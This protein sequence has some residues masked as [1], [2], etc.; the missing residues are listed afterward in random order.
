MS[1]RETLR[2]RT[3]LPTRDRIIVGALFG[4]VLVPLLGFLLFAMASSSGHSDPPASRWDWSNATEHE[5]LVYIDGQVGALLVPGDSGRHQVVGQGLEPTPFVLAARVLS[6]REGP[7]IGYVHGTPQFKVFGV[8]GPLVWCQEVS[9]QD[10]ERQDYAFEI[11]ENVPESKGSM[12]VPT[13]VTE[14]PT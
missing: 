13:P 1:R 8:V 7:L 6:S 12:S 5:L 4:I 3:L 11:R 9:R 2:K 10:A 14:C